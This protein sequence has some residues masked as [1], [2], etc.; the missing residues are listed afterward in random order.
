[1]AQPSNEAVYSPPT[2]MLGE[3]H[4]HI[5]RASRLMHEKTVIE[6][7]HGEGGLIVHQEDT[8]FETPGLTEL[9]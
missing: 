8:E 7:R 4:W 6:T 2:L 1:M 9:K 5:L 3:I